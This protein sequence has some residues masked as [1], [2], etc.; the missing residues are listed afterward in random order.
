MFSNEVRRNTSIVLALLAAA[1]L[2]GPAGCGRS[3][4]PEL[5]AVKGT[6]TLDGRPL[7]NASIRFQPVD[8]HG[9]GTYSIAMTGK[10]G[11]YELRHT[12]SSKG[13][14]VGRHVVKI[15][16]ARPDAEDELGNPLPVQELIPAVYNEHSEL[17]HEVRPGHN[18]IEFELSSSA[19]EVSSAHARR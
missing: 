2:T 3:S 9:A 4:G 11:E 18:T 8:E 1:M 5:A 14:L 7:K 10:K 6:V 12:R 15:R 16:T 13:A 17:I 19:S